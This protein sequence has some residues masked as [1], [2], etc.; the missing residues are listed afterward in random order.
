MSSVVGR[1][2]VAR[3]AAYATTKHGIIGLTRS[4]ALEL[5][6]KRITVNALCPGWVDTD[7]GRSGIALIAK[8]ENVSEDAAFE[9]AGKMAALGRV[10][11]PDEVAGLAAYLASDEA[12]SVTGQAIVIDGGQVMP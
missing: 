6:P 4:L 2:G 5:A 8:E 3:Y 7:M 10:L 9:L 1:F 11:T 12:K